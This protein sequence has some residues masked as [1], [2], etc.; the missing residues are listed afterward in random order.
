V[1]KWSTQ[2]LVAL[3]LT[4]ELLLKPFFVA[5]HKLYYILLSGVKS[6]HFHFWNVLIVLVNLTS[7]VKLY[8]PMFVHPTIKLIQVLSIVFTWYWSDKYGLLSNGFGWEVSGQ[9]HPLGIVCTV[10]R[11]YFTFQNS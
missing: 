3:L 4:S 8:F 1:I 2:N 6:I 11:I 7:L 9:I 10:P 5:C